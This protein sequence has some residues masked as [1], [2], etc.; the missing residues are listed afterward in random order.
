MFAGVCRCRVGFHFPLALK[1]RNLL[2]VWESPWTDMYVGGSTNS[3]EV[4]LQVWMQAKLV[5]ESAQ[6]HPPAAQMPLHCRLR[7]NC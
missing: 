1:V 7:H 5:L 6:S 4:L 2:Y 3:W